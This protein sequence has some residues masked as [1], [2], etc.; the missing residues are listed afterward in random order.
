[1]IGSVEINEHS[2]SVPRYCLHSLFL[3][4]LSTE[5]NLRCNLQ[6]KSLDFI[7]LLIFNELWVDFVHL[8][9]HESSCWRSTIS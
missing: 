9:Q 5:T 6:L 2:R 7:I 4:T 8:W 1:M 3:S